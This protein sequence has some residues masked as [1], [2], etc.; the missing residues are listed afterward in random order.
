M[1][2]GSMCPILTPQ[3]LVQGFTFESLLPLKNCTCQRR[4]GA[5]LI[6]TASTIVDAC[7]RIELSC[8][9]KWAF[10]DGVKNH[11]MTCS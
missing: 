8:G 4:L 7:A 6:E 11:A 2:S 3:K 5:V 9:C 1:P 10:I